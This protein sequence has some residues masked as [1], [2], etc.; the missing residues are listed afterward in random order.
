M[1]EEDF[2][3]LE[4]VYMEALAIIIRQLLTCE[5]FVQNFDQYYARSLRLYLKKLLI[6]FDFGEDNARFGKFD[7]HIFKA[8]IFLCLT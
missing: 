6:N 5:D 4:V 7:T 2:E 3:R 1:F 8:H